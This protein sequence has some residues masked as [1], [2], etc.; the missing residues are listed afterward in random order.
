M[1][2]LTNRFG[3]PSSKTHSF[4]WEA[5]EA[6]EVARERVADL[7]NAEPEEIVFTSGATEANNLVFKNGKNVI[8]STIEHSSIYTT[9]EK[10]NI[11]F[12]IG[13]DGKGVIDINSAISVKNSLSQ[14]D[15]ISVMLVN[16]E[17]G[18]I[19]PV[20]NIMKLYSHSTILH[21]DMA[22]ALGKVS[23]D[24]KSLGV[25]MASFSAH[26]LYGPKGVGAVY[27]SSSI[28]ENIKPLIYG[29]GQEFGLRGGTLNVP[30]IV[31]F[32]KT[33]SIAKENLIKDNEYINQLRNI[34]INTISNKLDG[35]NFHGSSNKIAGNINV[36][37][38]CENMDVFTNEISNK[39]ALSYGS[40]CA[41][42]SGKSRTL[43]AM[44]IQPEEISRSV[45]VC[46]GKFNTPEEAELSA[47][48]ICDAVNIANKE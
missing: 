37:L 25:N 15:I 44:S 27:I 43:T 31:G 21:S 2:Y 7:I 13:V 20:E 40:A 29:G 48:Y 4:G 19:Q 24:V 14:P 17:V 32:G 36:A 38:P 16:N 18:T 30:A 42:M 39:V 47:N 23:I 33:C 28:R 12:E 5:E 45:R 22:Q 35:L 1:P 3:N 34:F 6:I 10:R 26:K 9:A 46:F 11:V 41:S 8:I